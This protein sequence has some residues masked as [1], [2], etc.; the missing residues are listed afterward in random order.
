MLPGRRRLESGDLEPAPAPARRTHRN[1]RARRPSLPA[2]PARRLESRRQVERCPSELLL[3]RHHGHEGGPRRLPGHRHCIWRHERWR[4]GSRP[5]KR[6]A[7]RRPEESCRRRSCFDQSLH[8][9]LRRAEDVRAGPL[10]SRGAAPGCDPRLRPAARR[11]ARP[12]PLVCRGGLAGRLGAGQPR[13]RELL[14]VRLVDVH[15]ARAFV[16]AMRTRSGWAGAV[17]IALPQ[18]GL[19]LE[20]DSHLPR[21]RLELL[22]Q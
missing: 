21:R 7:A 10:H 1:R 8:H 3:Q 2:R 18:C 17:S 19:T 13:R 9:R 5:P 4:H 22:C 12:R 15:V 16:C 20:P 14:L 11:V 6:A